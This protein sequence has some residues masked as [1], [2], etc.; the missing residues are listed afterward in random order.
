MDRM[1]V[2]SG[3]ADDVRVS[4]ALDAAMNYA[5]AHNGISPLKAIVITNGS[6]QP[7]RD[8]NIEIKLAGVDPGRVAEPLR[9]RL[10]DIEP[11]ESLELPGQ[12]PRWTF[13]TATFAGLDEATTALVTVNVFNESRS[14]QM[15][16]TMRLLARDEWWAHSIEESLAAFV[17]PRARA[18]QEL[19]G[20]A[21]DLLAARTGDP[22]IQGYQG[23]SDRGMAIA[24]AIYDAMR[25][26]RIRYIDPPASFE[27]TGQKIRP[28]HEVLVDR[29]GTCLDLAVTYAAALEH[30]GLNPVLV[31]C[32][33]HAFA[34]HLLDRQQLP[35]LVLRDP[36]VILNLVEAGQFIPVETTALCA[37]ESPLTFEMATEDPRHRGWWSS[38]LA[39]VEC[40]VDVAAAHLAVRPLPAVTVEGGVRIVEIEAPAVATPTP[41]TMTRTVPAAPEVRG[42]SAAAQSFPPRVERWRSSL[43]DLSFRNPL[44]N[45]KT[46]RTALEVHVPSGALGTLEDMLFDG[47][48][49]TLVPHDQLAQI[50]HERGA[51]TAQD[52]E[53]STLTAILTSERVLFSACTEAAYKTRLRGI[54]RR[55]KTVVE[56]TGANNLFLTLGMLE[57]EDAKRQAKAPLFLLPVTLKAHRG[58]GFSIQIDD[59]GYP[60]PNQCLLEKLRIGHGLSIPDFSTP[61][62]DDSGIDLAGSLQA[63]RLALLDANLPFSVEESAHLTLVQF[64]TL[65]LWQ[66]LS[67][68]WEGFLENPVVR[69]LVETPT[70]SF[71]DPTTAPLPAD[72]E[73]QTYCPIP[74]DGTQLQAVSLAAAGRSFVIE[75]P[76]GTGKSQTITN[77]IANAVAAGKTILFVAEKQ[78]ALDV[79]RRRLD[80]VGLG[81]LC[82]DLHGKAQ[83]ADNVRKQLRAALHVQTTSNPSAWETVRSRHRTAVGS[84]SRCPAGLHESGGAGFSAWTARQTLLA[85]GEGLEVEVPAAVVAGPLDADALYGAAREL[86]DALYDL[87]VPAPAHPW[88]LA[89]LEDSDHPG[90]RE[91]VTATVH[92]LAR[93]VAAA[94]VG[95]LLGLLAVALDED[96]LAGIGRWL[97]V[98]ERP[99][100]D[101]SA[102]TEAG[103]DPW[104]LRLDQA[105]KAFRTLRTDAA[106]LLTTF[107]P[108]VVESVD[109]TALL[110]AA[111][112]ADGKLLKKKP[113]KAVIADLAAVS[114]PDATIEPGTLTATLERLVA[115]RAQ[116]RETTEDL[117]HLGGLA[118]PEDWN[119]L[120]EAAEATFEGQVAAIEAAVELVARTPEAL[121][122]LA[123]AGA[124]DFQATAPLAEALTAAWSGLCAAVGAT[125]ESVH[126][127]LGDDRTL[128]EAM[129]AELPAWVAD[130][131]GGLVQLGRWSQMYARRAQ[132]ERAGLS[133]FAAQAMAGTIPADAI[134]DVLRRS[135]ARAAL[136]ERLAAPGLAGFDG[137]V[138]DRAIERFAAGSDEMRRD[139]V[140]ELP[141]KIVTERSFS[142]ERLVG[143]VGELSRELSRKRGGLKIRELFHNYGPIIGELTPCLMM[144][145]HSVAKFLPA[146]SLDIDFVV[147][148]EASQ[149]RVAEAIGAM[150]RAKATV[151]VGDSQQMPPSNI[152]A[153]TTGEEESPE[154]GGVPSDM[155]SVLSEAVESNLPRVWLSWHYRSKHESLISFSN[156]QYYEGRLSSFP[157]PPEERSDLGVTWRRVEGTF[158][159]GGERVNRVEADAIVAE[160][161]A[162]LASAP[163]ASIGVVTFNTQQRDLIMDLLE[164]C[165]DERVTA[166]LAAS[167]DSLFVKN[168]E[169]VQGDERD[170]ILFSLAFSPSP[171]TGKL[172]LN[173]GP[174]IQAGGERRLNV[175]VTRA[176][177]QV[178]LFSSFDPSHIDLSRSSSVGLAHL[179]SY[180]EMAR[181]DADD[182]AVLRRALARDRHRDAVA[183]AFEAAGLCVRKDVGLSDFTV[184]IG[185]APSEEGP[186]VAVFLDGEGYASRST[187]T[188]RETLPQGVLVGAMGW[189]RVVRVWLPD[190]V[191]DPEAVV[192][193]VV[194]AAN[195]PAAPP[196]APAVEEFAVPEPDDADEDIEP[197]PLLAEAQ[198]ATPASAHAAYVPAEDRFVGLKEDLDEMAW[199]PVVRASVKAEVDDVIDT[200]GPVEVMRLARLVCRR[201]DLQRVARKRS[202]DVIA[203]IDQEQLDA[204]EFGTFAWPTDQVRSFDD[205]FRVPEE[206]D[207]ARVLPEVCPQELIG[208]MRFLARTGSGIDLEELVRETALI[209]GTR[210]LTAKPRAHLEA[211]AGHAVQSGALVRDG[212][213]LVCAS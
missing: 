88:R 66:D 44:L 8:L 57:W 91:Q 22:S 30:A 100:V 137:V 14:I 4:V 117:K 208:A 89:R 139:M 147:F 11:G 75:G 2:L 94:D 82:L 213:S 42:G 182:P 157:R 141:A 31:V 18:I 106:T 7:L 109:L 116:A 165:A 79:V 202:A 15:S 199:D 138:Q 175:A 20:E 33:N 73:A 196:L 37:G 111:R 54:Q 43:L 197:A 156:H 125:P 35:E 76:P 86:T 136:R 179:R 126:A 192:E 52:L 170:L 3:I 158:E 16:G 145:P 129:R 122:V 169:N 123:G 72:A 140:A 74:I 65:Q 103:G 161:R 59:G 115:L 191:R 168:L 212:E 209:F 150:G 45:M 119:P 134:E 195:E 200:E 124:E 83:T 178:V 19:I 67:E 25:A 95:R 206:D 198:P 132:L 174:L 185:V 51:R 154:I 203:L 151:V 81:E 97:A 163:D 68:N 121:E 85:L 112:A 49:L 173:F 166:G 34:G 61:Q 87:G 211:V 188:D 69:H 171:D 24:R 64:S 113:R 160:I 78:A 207:E 110:E 27:G 114:V 189:A 128:V 133:A 62:N 41:S 38:E 98:G 201:F 164:D 56:E 39:R 177:A 184:D 53:T 80:E 143:K 167:G 60:Q 190:W 159:R 105:R 104:R 70:D 183:E 146:G 32:D 101:A 55:A 50:H 193:R 181:R 108:S 176:R 46:G 127:W 152:A 84:L 17:T 144:S 12:G 204:T 187:V 131:S 142:P 29:W 172:P 210:R 130:A 63:I 194:R 40:L 5:L 180:M 99:F 6:A 90:V 135:V 26:R 13:D 93:A 120:E 102:I 92:A 148:D 23:G 36:K 58:R 186:W 10:P 162:R 118:L 107:T 1:L 155:E 9:A 71:S 21:S 48:S 149:V 153:V 28:A 77:L 47:Q 205:D 96:A